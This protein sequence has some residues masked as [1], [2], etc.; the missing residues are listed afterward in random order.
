MPTGR[1]RR[2]AALIWGPIFILLIF[3]VF[4]GEM[5]DFNEELGWPRWRSVPG[6]V[7]GVALILAGAG[8]AIY[9]SGLFARVGRGTPVPFDPPVKLVASGLYRYSRN[10]IYVADVAIWLGI[11]LFLGHLAL[12][13]Y[14]VLCTVAVQAVIVWWE[15]PDLRT[16][17]GEDYAR[18]VRSVPRWLPRPRPA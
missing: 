12:L 2:V 13:L 7:L 15:E 14:A 1:L 11:F 3:V 18:Y 17:F 9:C 16:R 10:P 4:P 6:Q 8:V 5:I